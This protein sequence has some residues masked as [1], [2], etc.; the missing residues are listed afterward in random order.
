MVYG[1][2]DSVMAR[3][4]PT[5]L[6]KVVTMGILT[7]IQCP[8]LIVPLTHH[9]LRQRGSGICDQEGCEAHQTSV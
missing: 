6:D 9:W 8:L 1:D 7:G 3:L 5:D 2:T 4:G